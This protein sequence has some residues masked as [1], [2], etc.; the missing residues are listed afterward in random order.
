M[1]LECKQ[2]GEP[3]WEGSGDEAAEKEDFS[4]KF[5]GCGRKNNGTEMFREGRSFDFR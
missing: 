2:F 5:G 3:E 4:K 1:N